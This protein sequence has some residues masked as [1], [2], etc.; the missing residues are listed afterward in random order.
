MK[1]RCGEELCKL[2]AKD[3]THKKYDKALTL[4]TPDRKGGCGVPGEKELA[5][6]LL[7]V[8]EMFPVDF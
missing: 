1:K 5:D 2:S 4:A 6:L 8:L 3:L 7:Y